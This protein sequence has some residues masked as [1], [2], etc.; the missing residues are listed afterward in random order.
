MNSTNEYYTANLISVVHAHSN[1]RAL[2][3]IDVHS[4]GLAAVRRC[5]YQ[6]QLARTGSNE[7]R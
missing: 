6:L 5:V 3:V 1:T 7:I 2:E 4:G